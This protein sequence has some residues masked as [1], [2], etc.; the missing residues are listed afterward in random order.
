MQWTEQRKGL[1]ICKWV[2]VKLPTDTQMHSSFAKIFS[3]PAVG[4]SFAATI[5][6]R[7]IACTL[8]PYAPWPISSN[9]CNSFN[10]R[11]RKTVVLVLQMSFR[12]CMCQMNQTQREKLHP[13]HSLHPASHPPTL[14]WTPTPLDVYSLVCNVDSLQNWIQATTACRHALPSISDTAHLR[15][16]YYSTCN[17]WYMMMCVHST[18]YNQ[19]E[20]YT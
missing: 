16:C 7:Q 2:Q 19:D 18:K 10:S 4:T 12:I 5:V 8:L 15:S 11:Y 17:C 6:L 14:P 3:F 13:L 1:S 20:L 9:T